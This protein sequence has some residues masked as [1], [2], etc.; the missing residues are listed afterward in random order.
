MKSKKY[1]QIFLRCDSIL[2]YRRDG[3]AVECGGL[4]N[5]WRATFPGFESLSLRQL[6]YPSYYKI[7]TIK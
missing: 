4:E 3:R 5:R 2:A 6:P 1:L 7:K